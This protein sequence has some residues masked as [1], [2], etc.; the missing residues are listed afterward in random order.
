MRAERQRTVVGVAAVVLLLAVIGSAIGGSWELEERDFGF[1]WSP[2]PAEVEEPVTEQPLELPEV[3]ESEG[4]GLGW[5]ATVLDIAVRVVIAALLVAAIV[6]LARWLWLRVRT[7]EAP[8][9]RPAPV[10][11][12]SIASAEPEPELP[13]LQRGVA[14]A[15][16]FLA[17][18]ER[19]VDAV[20]AAWLALEDA[21]EASGV[22]RGPAQTPT[23]FT[24]TVLERTSADAA[25]TAELLALYHRA[26]FSRQPLD[27]DAVTRASD[28]LGRLAASWDAVTAAGSGR[29]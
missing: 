18:I 1:E 14:A 16:W 11:G 5:L 19:P 28:C 27:D 6:W 26:R 2:E 15:Q 7:R 23:E 13:V 21:A 29:P 25:A 8:R 3:D 9:R 20:V 10:G 24:V 12:S 22:R 17:E 4:G